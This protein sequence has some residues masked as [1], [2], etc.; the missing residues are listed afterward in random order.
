[1]PRLPAKTSPRDVLSIRLRQLTAKMFSKDPPDAGTLRVMF[2]VLR[3][4]AAHHRLPLP[5]D[6][7]D[8][9]DEIV[10]AP[11]KVEPKIEVPVEIAPTVVF[12]PMFESSGD[13][14]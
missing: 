13:D 10:P 7:I 14:K 2:K 8:D 12:E 1:M 4:Y 3:M 9:G 11:I 5:I 6:F